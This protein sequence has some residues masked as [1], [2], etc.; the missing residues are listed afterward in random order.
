MD[1]A[2]THHRTT[3]ARPLARPRQATYTKVNTFDVLNGTF[4]FYTADEVKMLTRL[5]IDTSRKPFEQALFWLYRE[6]KQCERDGLF[7]TPPQCVNASNLVA[8]G[9]QLN[10]NKLLQY[11]KTMP[12]MLVH[13]QAF[14]CAVYLI[15]M[16]YDV[17]HAMGE[18]DRC[19][20]PR[21]AA[22]CRPVSQWM[23]ESDGGV[24]VCAHKGRAT[25]PSCPATMQMRPWF[26][27]PHAS[28]PRPPLGPARSSRSC[29]LRSARS[30]SCAR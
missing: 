1:Q 28:H 8:N 19:A 25:T 23:W 30:F 27:V 14:A 24:C 18:K 5:N 29:S 17:G 9:M 2:R 4:A 15:L 21:P 6:L 10:Y 11:R 3:V 7:N 16:S 26:P 22:V 12:L 13:L 20:P